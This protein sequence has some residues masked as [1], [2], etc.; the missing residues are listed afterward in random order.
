MRKAKEI[1]AGER[2]TSDQFRDRGAPQRGKE[3]KQRGT[4]SLNVQWKANNY[5]LSTDDCDEPALRR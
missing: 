2:Q 4:T 5:M 3:V 1:T